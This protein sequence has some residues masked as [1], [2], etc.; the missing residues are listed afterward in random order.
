MAKFTYQVDIKGEFESTGDSKPNILTD[1]QTIFNN[2]ISTG[3]WPD[4]WD[5]YLEEIEE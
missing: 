1:L 5:V 2:V 3:E 4:D